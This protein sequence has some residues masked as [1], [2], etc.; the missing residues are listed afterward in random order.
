MAASFLHV[1]LAAAVAGCSSAAADEAHGYWMNSPS[2]NGWREAVFRAGVPAQP[3]VLPPGVEPM[4]VGSSSPAAQMLVLEGMTH[5]LTFGDMRAF[6]KFDAALRLDPDCLMAHW[7][8]CMSLM[9][10]GPAFQEQRVHSMKRMKE[11]ALRPDCP[12]QER[13]Y[14]DALAVLLMDGPVKAQEAWK[15]I[16]STWK[17]DPYAPL[18]YAMLLRDGFDG[19]GNPGEGQKEA[20]RVVEAVLK[21]RPGSQAALFMRALLEEVAPS[22]S[23]ETVETARRAVA[24]NPF[25]ASAHHL[26]GHC[27]FRTGDYEGASAAFK[28]SENLCLAWEKAENVPPALDDAYF[29]SILYRAVSEFCAGHYK[30]A[31]AIASRA[32]SVPLDK[33]H[34]LAPGTLLQLWEA[35]T[36]PARLMLARP[37]IPRQALVLKA[38]PGPLPKGFPDLS[39]GMTAVATQYMGACYAARQGRTDAVASAFDKMSGILRLLMDGADAARRQMSVSYWARCLQTGSLYSSEIHSLMF[40]DSANVWMSEAIRSQRFSSLLLP[41]V[42]PY[43]AEWVLARAY[44]KAGKFREC[45]DMCEQ[46]L[47]RFPNHAGVLETLDKA[48]SSGK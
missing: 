34:P 27:L 40:P 48:R 21:E 4:M 25:S 22:I 31:E 19:Q 47:K 16:C 14:A 23:P 45:A 32:A 28:E 43:P 8:R 1:L 38:F 2:L 44:L 46:A 36:L 37:V 42:V 11:L 29:R 7:G 24:A 20:V 6:L 9:G 5:L 33:K 10:A 18:F 15:T 13:A 26:L 41:P 35:R 12:E 30:K 17:R 3:A 39:N